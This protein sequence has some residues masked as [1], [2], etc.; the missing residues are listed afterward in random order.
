MITREMYWKTGRVQGSLAR[1]AEKLYEDTPEEERQFLHTALVNLADIN[2]RGDYIKRKVRYSFLPKAT[3][4]AL[5][6][7]I[8]AR[9][10]IIFQD[11]RNIPWIEVAHEALFKN[12]PLL[13]HWIDIESDKLR[14]RNKIDLD[15]I[16]WEDHNRS[17]AYL[18]RGERLESALEIMRAESWSDNEPRK[19][20]LKK[21]QEI[22]LVEEKTKKQSESIFR[23]FKRLSA[24]QNVNIAI[25]TN[26]DL[27]LPLFLLLEQVT[28]QLE[29]D[30]A[31]VLLM[32]EKQE[33][34]LFVAGRGFQTDA[35]R[36][37]K[38]NVGEGLAGRVADSKEV[39]RINNLEAERTLLKHNPTLAREDFIAYYGIPLTSKGKVLGVL[40]LFNRSPL[41]PDAEWLNFLNL[42]A[43]ETA[44][45][46]DNALLYRDL[47]KSNLD[48]AIAYETTIEGWARTLELR[49]RETEGH[50]QRVL[51]LTMRLARKMNFTDDELVNIQR[52]AL[53]HDVGKMGIPDNVLLKES[54]LSAEE[55]EIMRKHPTYAYEMLSTIPFLKKAIDIP[56]CHH[57]K[58]DGSGFPRGLIGEEIPL[59]ARI[60][61]IVDVWDALRTDRPYRTAWSEERTLTYI[62][63]QSGKHFDPKIVEVFIREM[64]K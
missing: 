58:W 1:L 3:Q 28:D 21:S 10:I 34:L 45:A 32:D 54:P 37:T 63:E 7:F 44:V 15:V 24:L 16:D 52:G 61:S 2:E 41:N 5:E 27:Q 40:E 53:L 46:I 43:S 12:W 33:Q 39:V 38:L 22:A 17:I 57:E 9:L 20:F 48:L 59:S 30:A 50:S 26:I 62:K 42:L 6:R 51:D 13:N 55:W 8:Q 18:W 64:S 36:Y 23:Q 35:L 11:A 60:F 49:D 19:Q 29:V 4:H 47:E 31:D 14:L 25:T 56:Y